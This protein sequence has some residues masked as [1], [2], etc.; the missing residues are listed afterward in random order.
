[1]AKKKVLMHVDADVEQVFDQ[2]QRDKRQAHREASA[3]V[4]PTPVVSIQ[5]KHGP[6]LFDR[7]VRFVLFHNPVHCNCKKAIDEF[8]GSLQR[9]KV[10]TQI[11]ALIVLFDSFVYSLC[12]DTLFPNVCRSSNVPQRHRWKFS[13][14]YGIRGYWRRCASSG[15]SYWPELSSTHGALLIYLKSNMCNFHQLSTCCLFWF[16]W[17]CWWYS[18]KIAVGCCWQVSGVTSPCCLTQKL[19]K[20]LSELSS[21]LPFGVA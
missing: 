10:H 1:M 19:Y 3:V 17:F 8:C 13:R 4:G 18:Y 15:S 7:D 16:P 9:F 20:A 6:S 21:F 2:G 12:P 14:E 11:S 5:K